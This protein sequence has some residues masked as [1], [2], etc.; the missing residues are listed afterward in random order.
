MEMRKIKVAVI[1]NEPS[2]ELYVKS[3]ESAEPTGEF[4]PYFEGFPAA[5]LYYL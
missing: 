1:Y 3:D 5:C 2:P 4:V